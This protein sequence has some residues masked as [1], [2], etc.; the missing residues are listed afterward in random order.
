MLYEMVNT[1]DAHLF[2]SVN[3]HGERRAGKHL[4]EPNMPPLPI[5]RSRHAQ[6]VS[7]ADRKRRKLALQDAA[8][9]LQIATA[10]SDPVEVR[11]LQLLYM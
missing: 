5:R 3:V 11:D 8:L 4:P 7:G 9:P 6:T 1:I 10:A 2:R